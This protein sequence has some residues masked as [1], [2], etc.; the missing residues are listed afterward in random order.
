MPGLVVN[1]ITESRGI[2]D[3][4]GDPGAFVIQFEFFRGS[5]VSTRA[6]GDNDFN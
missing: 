5:T 3:R 1:L 2:N 4:K 6:I